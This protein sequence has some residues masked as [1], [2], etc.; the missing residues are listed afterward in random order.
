LIAASQVGP[1][2][3]VYAFEFNPPVFGQLAAHVGHGLTTGA[4]VGRRV[5]S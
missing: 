3:R 1:S 2:G 4:L 5:R